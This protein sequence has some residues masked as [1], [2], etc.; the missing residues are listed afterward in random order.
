[1]S[2][3][4]SILSHGG[5]RRTLGIYFLHNPESDQVGLQQLRYLLIWEQKRWLKKGLRRVK[6]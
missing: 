1:L 2:P 4:T 6:K 3:L 5:E